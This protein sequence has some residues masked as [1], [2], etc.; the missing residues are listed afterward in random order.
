MYEIY[1][2]DHPGGGQ[3]IATATDYRIAQACMAAAIEAIAGQVKA[4]GAGGLWLQLD[5]YDT[6]GDGNPVESQAMM[7]MPALRPEDIDSRLPAGP[8]P[9][10]ACEL[11]QLLDDEVADR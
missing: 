11:E 7:I 3:V 4:T 6:A 8:A 1:D 5:L 2:P 10:G 9:P